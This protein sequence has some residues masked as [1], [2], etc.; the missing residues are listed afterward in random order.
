[1]S[2]NTHFTVEFKIVKTVLIIQGI[3]RLMV[4]GDQEDMKTMSRII[5]LRDNL[6][7]DTLL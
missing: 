7:G 3:L 1:M 5:Y 2:I 4:N 6:L